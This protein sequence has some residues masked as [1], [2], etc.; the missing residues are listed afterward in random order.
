[1]SLLGHIRHIS[2][3]IGLRG[4]AT[5]GEAQAADYVQERLSEW[6]LQPERQPVLSA[7]SAYAPVPEGD[8][9]RL[10]AVDAEDRA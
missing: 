1:M 2:E 9:P 6:G 8:L 7:T 10:Q 4:S 3:D 5:E